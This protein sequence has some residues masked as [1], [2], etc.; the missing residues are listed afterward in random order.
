MR[1]HVRDSGRASTLPAVAGAADDFRPF[2]VDDDVARRTRALAAA[3]R[4]DARHQVIDRRAHHRR[5]VDGVD[6]VLLT[7]VFDVS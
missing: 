3:I 1:R 2:V 5:A 6:D 7:I 4:V